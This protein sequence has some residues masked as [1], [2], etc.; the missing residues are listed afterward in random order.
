MSVRFGLFSLR[1][2]KLQDGENCM[3]NDV[4]MCSLHKMLRYL[5][6]GGCDGRDMQYARKRRIIVGKL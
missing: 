4:L 2:K 3:L 5:N 6:E 1:M